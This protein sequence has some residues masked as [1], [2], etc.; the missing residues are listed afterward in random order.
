MAQD[1]RGFF[2]SSH[3]TSRLESD[4]A[5]SSSGNEDDRTD[6]SHPKRIQLDSE[7]TVPRRKA[8]RKYNKQWEKVYVWLEY[9]EEDQGAFC[10]ICKTWSRTHGKK[11]K[12]VWVTTPFNNWKNA[13]E[14]MKIHTQSDQHK[15]ACQTEMAGS[16]AQNQGTIIWQ[17]QQIG[18]DVRVKNRMIIKILIRCTHFLVRHHIPHTTVY[19]DRSGSFRTA[20]H[21]ISSIS[22]SMQQGMPHTCRSSL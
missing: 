1:I 12:G 7:I 2:C 17:L 15:D 22:R 5:S 16:E 4:T 18:E 13:L 3:E 10:R 20:E 6:V 21:R 8:K 11:A 14:K 9:S 19:E